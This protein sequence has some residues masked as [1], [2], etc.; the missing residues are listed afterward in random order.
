L[1]STGAGESGP[2]GTQAPFNEVDMK[3]LESR[4]KQGPHALGY[5][6]NL[7]TLERVSKLIEWDFG[8]QYT[9]GSWAGF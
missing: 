7:W 5:E 2:S 3:K 6:T 1:R 8:V 4:L 9:P